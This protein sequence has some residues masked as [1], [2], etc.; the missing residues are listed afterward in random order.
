LVGGADFVIENVSMENLSE[1][2]FLSS[3]SKGRISSSRFWGPGGLKVHNAFE[4]TIE[5]NSFRDAA[6]EIT[7]A[8]SMG[9]NLHYNTVEGGQ[10]AHV[11][12]SGVLNASLR[13]NR[14]VGGV[15]MIQ[16][17]ASEEYRSHDIDGSNVVNGRP[18]VYLRDLEGAVLVNASAGE[19]IVANCTEVLVSRLQAEGGAA[20][21]ILGYSKNVR[22][23]NLSVAALGAPAVSAY[24]VEGLSIEDSAILQNSTDSRTYWSETGAVSLGMARNVSLERTR[25]NG[26]GP[27][28]LYFA[29]GANLTIEESSIAGRLYGAYLHSID[30]VA[31]RSTRFWADFGALKGQTLRN[32]IISDSEFRGG[33]GILLDDSR[34]STIVGN[35]LDGLVSGAVGVSYSTNVKILRNQVR[36]SSVG[37][38]LSGTLEV[39]T[40]DGNSLVGNREG[41]RI[42]ARG[43]NEALVI[44]RNNTVEQ[45]GVG[46]VGNLSAGVLFYHNRFL[47]NTGQAFVTPGGQWDGGYLIGGNFWSDYS[48]SDN[49]SGPSQDAC[50]DPDKFGDTPYCLPGPPGVSEAMDHYP[51]MNLTPPPARQPPP[52]PIEPAN[53]TALDPI[54]AG[55]P[56]I[57][58]VLAAIAAGIFLAMRRKPI[59]K[60]EDEEIERLS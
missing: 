22:L 37:I 11:V 34:D 42:E 20:P 8:D 54:N 23:S 30:Q 21:I 26:S 18:L 55:L 27:W 43:H 10:Y 12:L 45:N 52:P 53:P 49:C 51:L 15:V 58:L 3:V 1:G 6:R 44:V 50:P 13:G 38:S 16:G 19:L 40:V 14:I 36:N 5:G 47:N 2:I 17:R 4:L 60:L 24:E 35:T 39:V 25:I 32:A 46:V 31:I 59:E 41:L 48:G 28:G 29:G 57:A 7:I 33:G 9:V 56:A